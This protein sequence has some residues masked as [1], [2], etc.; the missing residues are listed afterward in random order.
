MPNDEIL[1]IGS[2]VKDFVSSFLEQVKAGVTEQNFT[3]CK[4]EDAHAEIELNAI[5]TKEADGGIKLH[6]FSAG[7]KLE[8]TNSQKIKVY[9]KKKSDYFAKQPQKE[10]T[11]H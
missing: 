1:S 2:P 10:N 8:G 3:F 9:V 5:E 7:G 11:G 4:K 6:I